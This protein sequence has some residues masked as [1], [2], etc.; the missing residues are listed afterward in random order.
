[1]RQAKAALGEDARLI[2]ARRVSTPGAPAVYEV[3]VAATSADGPSATLTE[4]RREVDA[5]RDT[6]RSMGGLGA[7]DST[8]VRL[9][10]DA[11]R[12]SDTL[13]RRGVSL[14]LACELA[15]EAFA[16]PADDPI[17]ALAS[18]IRA[19]FVRATRDV[20]GE[21]FAIVVAGP[22]GAGKT[23]VLSRVATDRMLRGQRPTLVS[24]DGESVHG[25]DSL[26][27]IAEALDLPFETAFLSGQLEA[28][29]ERLGPNVSLL[30]D[31]PGRSAFDAASIEEWRTTF[32]TLPDADVIGVLPVST[33]VDEARRMGR[34]LANAGARR[35]VLTKLD[36]AA[37]PGR[38]LDLAA[39]L[40]RPVA[41]VT[42][43]R[44]MRATAGSLDDRRVVTRI[45]GTEQRVS[46]S[47]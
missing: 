9:E 17:A 34:S 12:W 1:M 38:V 8:S 29:V 21:A 36:E 37:C 40:E 20:L 42:F 22:S 41:Q 31:T 10:G 25:A 4:L 27:R 35:F 18:A 30:V 26:Q 46:R 2:S 13:Y 14:S 44:R 6:V 5:L 19:R 33:D 11:A 47:V 43:G 28:L 45:V 16:A 23:T 7:V 15:A 3:H 32:G 39:A 24:T